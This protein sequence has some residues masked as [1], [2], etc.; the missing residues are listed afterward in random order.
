MRLVTWN[1][2]QGGGPSR[3]P[4]IALALLEHEPDLCVLTEFR[5]ARGGAL[6]AILADRGLEHH[7]VDAGDE[8]G[9]SLLL[10]SRWPLRVDPRREGP[11]PAGR[12][13]DV[14]IDAL[15]LEVTGVHIPDDS[16]RAEKAG[17]WGHLV[18]LARARA[19]GRWIVLGDANSGRRGIDEAG[20]TF[21]ATA[22]LGSFFSL[23]MLDAWRHQHPDS[24][25]R[26]WV[27]PARGGTRIDACYLSRDLHKSLK[28]SHFSHVERERGLSDHSLLVVDVGVEGS[29]PKGEIQA[30][31]SLFGDAPWQIHLGKAA[32]RT[33][34]TPKKP[35]KIGGV[36]YPET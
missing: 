34:P 10:A 32:A 9:N 3:L 19:K 20:R 21:T 28:N 18:E 6:R 7:A 2:R 23:G 35:A 31:T 27:H 13:M 14:R 25:E 12:W 24:P 36:A 15:D 26:S 8:G 29:A 5:V 11:F 30:K 17:C 16:R 1:I 22:L 33:L 4:E